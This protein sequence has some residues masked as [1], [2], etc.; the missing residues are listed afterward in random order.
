MVENKTWI[1][2]SIVL[3]ITALSAIGY[4][5]TD[6]TYFCEERGIVMDCARFS[7]S[8]LR[9]YPSLT[10]TSGYKDCSAGWIKISEP[11]EIEKD[12]SKEIKVFANAENYICEVIDG[13]V[14]SYSKCNSET[15]KKAYLGELV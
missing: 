15:N 12:L 10:T 13:K 7:A 8:G 3:L 6:Q 9:C 5:F 2:I 14:Y 1:G 11:I 4:T